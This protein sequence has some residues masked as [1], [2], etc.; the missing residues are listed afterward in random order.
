M[1]MLDLFRQWQKKADLRY[2]ARRFRGLGIVQELE[3]RRVLSAVYDAGTQTLTITSDL[4]PTNNV[5]ITQDSSG[6]TV[7]QNNSVAFTGNVVVNTMKYLGNSSDDNVKIVSLFQTTALTVDG[8]GGNNSLTALRPPF[9]PNLPPPPSATSTWNIT[10][11]NSGTW[12]GNNFYSIQNLQGGLGVDRFVFSPSGIISGTIDGGGGVDTLNYAALNKGVVINLGTN[13]ATG[14]GSGFQN[15]SDF[16]GS[17]DNTDLLIGPNTSNFWQITGGNTGNVNTQKFYYGIENI[18]G[19]TDNDSFAVIPGGFQSGKVAGGTGSNRIDYSALTSGVSTNLQ[20]SSS[21][22][23][24]GNFFQIGTIIG[25]SAG[26]DT[27]TGPNADTNWTISGSNSGSVKSPAFLMNFA[28]YE[29]LQGGSSF[30]RFRFAAGGS[31]LGNLNGGFG[32]NTLDYSQIAPPPP[33]KLGDPP[34]P[35]HPPLGIITN[36]QTRTSTGIGGTFLNIQNLLGTSGNVPQDYDTL[37]GT[38]G[39]SNW[40]ISG[41][42]TGVL[43]TANGNFY[44]SSIENL[45]GGSSSDSFNFLGGFVSGTIQGG[46]GNNTLDYSNGFGGSVVNLQ[47]SPTTGLMSAT[48][49]GGGFGQIQNYIGSSSAAQGNFDTLFGANSSNNWSITG[50]N[51]GTLNGDF[52][53]TGIENLAGGTSVDIFKLSTGGFQTGTIRGNVD[54]SGGDWLDYSSFITPVT[55][56][57]AAGTATGIAAIANIQNVHGGDG[58]NTLAGNSRGNILV[59]GVSDDTITGGTGRSLLIGGAGSDTVNGNSSDDIVISTYTIYDANLAALSSIFAEWTSAATFD[60]RVA[61]LR[62]GGGLNGSNVLIADVTV[63]ND[64]VLDSISGGGGRNWLWGQPAEIHG[65]TAQDLI[66][67]P[68]NNP[69]V[70]AGMTS[71]T[72]TAKTGGQVVNPIITVTDVD[73]ATLASATVRIASNYNSLQDSLGFTPSTETGNIVGSYNSTTGTMTLTSMFATATVAQFQAALRLVTYTNISAN[74]NTATRTIEYQ[75]NDGLSSS[76]TLNTPVYFNFPATLSGTNAITYQAGQLPTAI[77]PNLTITD[78]NSLTLSYATV[79]LSN[80][81]FSSQDYLTFAGDS[82]TG[83]I[84]SSYNATTG[85]LTLYSAAQPATVAQFQAALRKVAYYNFSSTPT[86]FPRTVTYQ[87]NDGNVF[88]NSVTATVNVIP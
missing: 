79:G 18:Q 2:R 55:V 46:K 51:T 80:F 60:Q 84:T 45:A 67:T 57:L 69:P 42:N 11:A 53:F 29:N 86:L 26:T 75:V 43:T 83:N 25:S 66:D 5:E 33:P 68:I 49:V 71:L 70:L 17:S 63:R 74:P 48:G 61:H 73:S 15:I 81:F 38:D 31:I 7:L 88:S 22:G 23:I 72:Y 37:I 10:S 28:G 19:G 62:L 77:N 76:N 54:N 40:N 21:T 4:T 3:Q 14:I 82:T 6:V 52:N 56:N 16:V 24:G 85:T 50:K 30:D 64:V 36:L 78:P 13:S 58:V 35:P 1:G 44:F 9:D 8:G 27:L 39:A 65:A 47:Q 87:V 32:Q 20:F 41:G 12:N 34:L 59:G